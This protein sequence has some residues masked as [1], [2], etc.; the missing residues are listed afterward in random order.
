MSELI[1]PKTIKKSLSQIPISSKAQFFL[2]T[3]EN[4]VIRH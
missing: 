1:T 2:M 3:W 4:K